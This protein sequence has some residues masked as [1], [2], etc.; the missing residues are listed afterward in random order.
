[1][2]RFFPL[3]LCGLLSCAQALA[4]VNDGGMRLSSQGIIDGVIADS[5]G[6]HGTQKVGST[7]T[8]SLP[9]LVEGVPEDTVCYALQMLDPDSEPLCGYQWVHW[10]ATNFT[11]TALPEN[12][13]IDQAY[14]MA[15]GRNDFGE[16]GYG[17]PTPPDK[18]HTYLLTVYALDEAL[19]L[20]DGF[21]K[22]EFTS[23]LDGHILA[24]A[25]IAGSY[26]N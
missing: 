21:S 19:P 10:M 25:T 7:P 22:E 9:L 11:E 20:E 2:K 16:N 26:S 13:S 23:A 6:A 18:P 3:L 4:G 1:M 8:L 5:Y 24:E 17:G 12:A 14:N 15:Q